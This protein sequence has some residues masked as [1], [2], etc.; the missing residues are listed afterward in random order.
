MRKH[1]D[2]AKLQEHSL[3]TIGAMALRS[4]DNS[5]Q[6]VGLGVVPVVLRAMQAHATDGSIQRQVSQSVSHLV[7]M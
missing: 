6:L 7:I 1:P 2:D 3:A 4:P 5:L